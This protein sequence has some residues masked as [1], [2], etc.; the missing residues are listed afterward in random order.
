MI[1][2]ILLYLVV[3]SYFVYLYL[4]L[5]KNFF[6]RKPDEFINDYKRFNRNVLLTS[7]FTVFLTF[8]LLSKTSSNESISQSNVGIALATGTFIFYT[9]FLFWDIIKV[10]IG[11]SFIDS[12]LNIESTKFLSISSTVVISSISILILEVVLSI[13]MLIGG[14]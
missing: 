3:I 11:Q 8:E 2:I 7:V 13:M 6:L 12:D 4:Y 1:N 10:K 14:I 9:V 5:K